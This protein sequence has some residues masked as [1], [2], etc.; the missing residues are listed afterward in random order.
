MDDFSRIPEAD[1]LVLTTRMYT[2]LR[3]NPEIAAALTDYGY[4]KTAADDGLALVAALRDAMRVQSSE[5]GD[6]LSAGKASTLATAAV[7]TPFVRH[8][9]L[10]RRSHP[11]GSAGHAALDLGGPAPTTERALFVAVRHFYQNAP[12]VDGTIRSLTPE[13]IT[14]AHARL[15]T[16]E[17]AEDSQIREAGES[18]RATALRQS[19]EAALRA[20]AAELAEAATDA[21]TDAPQLCEVLGL[22][23]RGS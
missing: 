7:R 19:A 16:A 20:E 3:D 4:G 2:G 17:A 22:M 10:A 11:R 12:D 14:A 21:L 5:A 8:P 18:Q 23:E 6:K 15:D 1:L 9:R 13:A